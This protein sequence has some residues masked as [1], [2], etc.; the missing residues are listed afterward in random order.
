MPVDFSFGLR[1]MQDNHQRF[2]RA[3]LAVVLRVKNFDSDAMEAGR[4]G[5]IWTPTGGTTPGTSDIVISPPPDVIDVASK[6]EGIELQNEYKITKKFTISH[7]FVLNRMAQMGYTDPYQVFR[8][9]TVL[10]LVYN[11]RLYAIDSVLSDDSS[12]DMIRWY[13]TANAVEKGATT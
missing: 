9:K 3:G 5:F 8:S 12:G 6:D 13:I 10:G 1:Y 4:L 7:T 2:V 11:S